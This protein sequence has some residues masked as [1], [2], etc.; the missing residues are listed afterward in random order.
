M[1]LRSMCMF[2]TFIQVT[3]H[4]ML[5]HLRST[6]PSLDPAPVTYLGMDVWGTEGVPAWEDGQDGGDAM[7]VGD[8]D[9]PEEAGRLDR[10]KMQGPL[11]VR[12]P[13]GFPM[14]ATMRVILL[15]TPTWLRTILNMPRMAASTIKGPMGWPIMGWVIK[16]P[17]PMPW[18]I[19]MVMESLGRPIMG[20]V[21]S[22]ARA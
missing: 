21:V 11:P 17:L 18:F 10:V 1:T 9:P 12:G 15:G 14:W 5:P 6:Q 16:R 2:L 20:W 8:G 13:M 22:E 4:T 7:L 3:S 19:R